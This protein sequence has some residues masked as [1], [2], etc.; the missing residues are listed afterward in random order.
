V[1]RDKMADEIEQEEISE[2]QERS[3]R[4]MKGTEQPQYV[5]V[6]CFLVRTLE[7]ALDLQP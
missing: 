5:I 7:I 4:I 6:A 3:D 1:E 2:R